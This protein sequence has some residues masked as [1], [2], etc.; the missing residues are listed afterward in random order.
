LGLE[1]VSFTAKIISRMSHIYDAFKTSISYTEFIHYNQYVQG[2]MDNEA[3]IKHNFENENIVCQSARCSED[4]LAEAA[5]KY[6]D[7]MRELE[8]VSNSIREII[9][10]MLNDIQILKF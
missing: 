5:Q 3:A 10:T 1:F 8:P 2:L 6:K 9:Q 7:E 4:C